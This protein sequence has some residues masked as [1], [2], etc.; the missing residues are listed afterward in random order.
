MTYKAIILSLQE[1]VQKLLEDLNVY[2]EN[3]F[4]VLR[5]LHVFTSS[6]PKYPLG[7][8]V[9]QCYSIL[10]KHVLLFHG[11]A[12]EQ[13]STL[14][15]YVLF[16]WFALCFPNGDRFFLIM[17][18]EEQ[19]VLFLVVGMVLHQSAGRSLQEEADGQIS[20]RIGR[21]TFPHLEP[22]VCVADNVY[23]STT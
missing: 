12:S 6:L 10:V 21:L 4:P 3:Y 23:S 2:H 5:C 22:S 7:K 20:K 18:R 15:L 19:H 17:G 9:R 1:T 14:S 11:M 16:Y 13:V 8:Q